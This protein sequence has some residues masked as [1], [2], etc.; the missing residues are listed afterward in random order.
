MKTITKRESIYTIVAITL[1][2]I[3]LTSD[4]FTSYNSYMSHVNA[5]KKS[6]ETWQNINVAAVKGLINALTHPEE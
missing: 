6:N 1:I 3:L 5:V 2:I 4:A